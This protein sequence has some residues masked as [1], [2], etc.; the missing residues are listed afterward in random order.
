[1]GNVKREVGEKNVEAESLQQR[2]AES[3]DKVTA[4][5]AKKEI[6]EEN[7]YKNGAKMGE[8]RL[9]TGVKKKIL[10]F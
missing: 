1:M 4:G 7:T 8:K 5:A 2:N 10:S 3:G 9:K 6:K